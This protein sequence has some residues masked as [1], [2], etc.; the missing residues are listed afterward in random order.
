M[1]M[2]AI[3][4]SIGLVLALLSVADAAPLYLKC[5]GKDGPTEPQPASHSIKID[6]T[7]VEVDGQSGGQIR[8]SG[9]PI[10]VFGD[11]KEKISGTIDRITGRAF[12]SFNEMGRMAAKLWEGQD[13]PPLPTPSFRGTCRKAEKLF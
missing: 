8:N 9:D 2:R 6:G 11:E 12:L 13:T 1:R 10:W 5:E 7:T 4:I 3:I